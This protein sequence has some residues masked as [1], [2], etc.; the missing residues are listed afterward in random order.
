MGFVT[1]RGFKCFPFLMKVSH[2]TFL[3]TK[4]KGTVHLLT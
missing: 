1:L 2:S 3:A 4:S